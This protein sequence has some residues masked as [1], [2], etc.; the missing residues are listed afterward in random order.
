MTLPTFNEIWSRYLFNQS[1][2]ITGDDLLDE[3]LIR[4]QLISENKL[5]TGAVLE[6]SAVDFMAEGAPGSFVTGANFSFMNYFFGNH[7]DPNNQDSGPLHALQYN[8]SNTY[9]RS[10]A[11]KSNGA[12]KIDADGTIHFTLA[13]IMYLNEQAT[14][15]NRVEALNINS[16][17]KV[18]SKSISQR[19]FLPDGESDYDFAQRVQLFSSTNFQVGDKENDSKVEFIIKPDGTREVRNFVI[20]PVET[21]DN[22]DFLGANGESSQEIGNEVNQIQTDPSNIGRQVPFQY[23]N[24]ESV[25]KSTYDL[26]DFF[27][28]QSSLEINN[29]TESSTVIYTRTALNVLPG[30]MQ[31][32]KELYANDVISFKDSEGRYVGYGTNE[33][34]KIDLTEWRRSEFIRLN[35]L[36]VSIDYYNGVA[37]VAGD[38]SDEVR[39]TDNNDKILGGDGNDYLYGGIEGPDYGF[40]DD[41]LIIGG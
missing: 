23:T 37:F 5:Y 39:G 25:P 2:P 13:Q 20:T 14:E 10:V 41:D 19:A 8:N 38:G 26:D 35:L 11:E 28:D 3:N 32:F 34:D 18:W 16:N 4:P 24:L 33:N 29:Y 7:Y 36:S 12:V 21:G 1:T 30:S 17:P 22:F 31:M 6:I 27:R 40:G 15:E 9:L